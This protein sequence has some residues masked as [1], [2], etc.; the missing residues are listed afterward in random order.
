[1]GDLIGE[2]KKK[3]EHNYLTMMFRTCFTQNNILRPT[4]VYRVFN[5]S[6]FIGGFLKSILLGEKDLSVLGKVPVAMVTSDFSI[7][8]TS[9]S[10]T[11]I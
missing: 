6:L 3:N 11:F 5:S 4:V 10:K 8:I 1:M 2:E 9:S 7:F